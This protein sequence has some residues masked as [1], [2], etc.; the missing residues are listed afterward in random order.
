[1]SQSC[2]AATSAERFC[3]CLA[4]LVSL[5]IALDAWLTLGP[6]VQGSL[7][8]AADCHDVSLLVNNAGV[9][10][11]SPMLGIESE[12]AAGTHI[13]PSM[14]DAVG[15]FNTAGARAAFA[16][17]LLRRWRCRILPGDTR[18]GYGRST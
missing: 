10:R 12:G 7:M 4:L 11:N 13:T 5:A 17:V 18:S 9:L 16:L 8:A 15:S 3:Y 1:M 6:L 2:N 14:S